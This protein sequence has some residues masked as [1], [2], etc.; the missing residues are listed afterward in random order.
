MP[1]FFKKVTYAYDL[2]QE[3]IAQVP[4]EPRDSCRLLEVERATG[5]LTDRNF[6]DI[7]HLLRPGDLILRND[8]RVM[9]A[10]LFGQRETGGT[11]EVLLLRPLPEG[12]HW[13]AL[14]RPSKKCKTGSMLRFGNQLAQMGEVLSK[15]GTR[16]VIFPPQTDVSTLMHNLGELPL[17]PYITS[18]ASNAEDYQTV[19]SKE[20]KSSAAPTAGL[21]FTQELFDRLKEKGVSTADLT[22]EVGLGTFRPLTQDDIRDHVM[23]RER[24]RVPL[25]TQEAI[26]ATK[27]KG[28]R[29]IALGTTVTRTIEAWWRNPCGEAWFE[30]ELF[31]YPGFDFAIIDGLITNFH[32]PESTLLMLVSAFAG[33]RSTMAAYAH[34]VRERYR[35]FSFGDAMLI[36]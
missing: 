19:Y 12:G 36:H 1:D 34:A 31:I 21:H 9:P 35:F 22:L 5:N 30:T 28:G 27:Q 10:R 14:V 11:A 23:H 2:P 24:C 17:P 8:T 25:Q 13:E 33:Y 15:D 16:R 32:L 18:R 6:K 3:L 4:A 20:E 29:V 7:V 26:F